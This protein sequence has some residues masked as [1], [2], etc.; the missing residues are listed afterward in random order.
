[1]N[2]LETQTIDRLKLRQIVGFAWIIRADVVRGRKRHPLERMV[3]ERIV[4]R[5][6]VLEEVDSFHVFAVE[7]FPLRF[8][9]AKLVAV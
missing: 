7:P 3:L 2:K 9:S 8:G 6:V 1:M 5:I 4:E